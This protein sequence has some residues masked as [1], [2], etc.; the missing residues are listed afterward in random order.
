M[1]ELFT[2]MARYQPHIMTSG[3]SN[4]EGSRDASTILSTFL[5]FS[6]HLSV[7]SL[8]SGKGLDILTFTG[9]QSLYVCMYIHLSHW[10]IALKRIRK[11]LWLSVYCNSYFTQTDYL[12]SL[13]PNSF[14]TILADES[15]S[16]ALKECMFRGVQLSVIDTSVM[17]LG[18]MYLLRLCLIYV[19]LCS[20]Y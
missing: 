17:S 16:L 12:L 1:Y 18:V 10:N 4:E 3:H 8:L 9:Q 2:R 7:V 6:F 20:R 15:P 11:P 19:L 5:W 13:L 14:L